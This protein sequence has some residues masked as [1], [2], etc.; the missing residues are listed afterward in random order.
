[1]IDNK[2]LGEKTVRIVKEL[3]GVKS[4]SVVSLQEAIREASSQD[5]D[6]ICIS[7]I[8]GNMVAIIDNLEKYNYRKQKEKKL[9]EKKQRA[10][11]QD[12]KEIWFSDSINEHDV[13]TKVKQIT[14]F[15]VKENSIVKLG[16]K[17]KGREIQN[18]KFGQEKIEKIIEKINETVETVL[19]TKFQRSD[20]QLTITIK[21]K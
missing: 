11:V 8:P 6:L 19:V 3:N 17:Y 18:I 16:I 1:M 15:L 10:S 4:S 5:L 20:R 2:L 21:K 12:T 13:N 14:K 9:K 7:D